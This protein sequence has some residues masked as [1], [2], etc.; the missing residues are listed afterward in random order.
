MS[1]K[2]LFGSQ[3]SNNKVAH[4]LSLCVCIVSF[5]WAVCAYSAAKYVNP[6]LNTEI[7]ELIEQGVRS[8]ESPKAIP[9]YVWR[10]LGNQLNKKIYRWQRFA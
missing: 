8:G 4:Y 9:C 3:S 1:T 2:I 6:S 7:H 10:H 5:F